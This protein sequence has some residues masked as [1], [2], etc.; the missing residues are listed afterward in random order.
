MDDYKKN[1]VNEMDEIVMDSWLGN[2]DYESFDDYQKDMES[3]TFKKF[4]GECN[5]V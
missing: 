3:F 1:V 2:H 4:K 5:N